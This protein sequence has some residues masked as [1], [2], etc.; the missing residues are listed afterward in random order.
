MNNPEDSKIKGTAILIIRKMHVRSTL[1][2]HSPP[3]KLAK[4]RK[5]ADTVGGNIMKLVGGSIVELPLTPLQRTL[6]IAKKIPDEHT[7]WL[8]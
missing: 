5:A 2:S 7:L 4:P 3:S 8:S 1:K 6:A